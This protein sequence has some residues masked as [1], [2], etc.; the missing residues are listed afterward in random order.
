M[1]RAKYK[2]SD[3]PK[4]RAMES[5]APA[6]NNGRNPGWAKR[7]TIATAEKMRADRLEKESRGEVEWAEAGLPVPNTSRRCPACASD[8]SVKDLT[9]HDACYRVI[10]ACPCYWDRKI[11]DIRMGVVYE[12][13]REQD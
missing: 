4:G 11:R 13:V 5:W 10:C 3:T 9:V 6:S 1:P 2:P 12:D 7:N 8:P